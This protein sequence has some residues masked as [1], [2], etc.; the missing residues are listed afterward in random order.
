MSMALARTKTNTKSGKPA[1]V[2]ELLSALGDIDP[3]RIRME[4]APGTATE[5]DVLK[6]SEK[7]D[8]VYELVDGTLVEKAMGWGE[9]DLA[10]WLIELFN[11]YLRESDL[12]RAYG[13][14]SLIRLA[15]DKARA[16]DVVVLLWDHVPSAED[17]AKHPIARTVPDLVVEVISPSNSRKEIARK[18]KEYFSARTTLV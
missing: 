12:G 15:K 13:G 7:D 6:F 11:E 14:D 4:P 18:R 1:T 10:Y 2:A 17:N 9:T 5:A 8:T 3:E 16:P